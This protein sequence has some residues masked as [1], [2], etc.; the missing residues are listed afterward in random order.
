M[1]LKAVISLTLTFFFVWSQ[2]CLANPK[3]VQAGLCPKELD[4]MPILQNGRLK[5]LYVHSKETFS[6]LGIKVKGPLT[7]TQ[8]YCL[9]SLEGL[10]VPNDLNLQTP[11]QHIKLRKFLE[12][13]EDQ[14]TVSFKTLLKKAEK[15][16][17]KLMRMK[18]ETSE[19]KAF[20]KI[21]NKIHLYNSIRTSNDWTLFDKDKTGGTTWPVLG[22]YLTEK[23][24]KKTF[25]NYPSENPIVKTLLLTKKDYIQK[26]G[27]RYLVEYHFVKAN[28]P[29]W[30]LILSLVTLAS[31]TLF[32]KRLGFIL[33]C[34]GATFLLQLIMMV[35]RIYI[36]GRAPITNMYET[37][38]FSGFGCLA[39][40]LLIGH[41]KKEKVFVF[42]GVG[43]NILT[44]LMINFADGMLNEQISPLVPVLRDNFWLSTH[45]TTI[46]MSYG[47]LAMSWVLGN[48]ILVKKCF[49]GISK[50][51][52]KY[53]SEKVYTCL[54]W[55]TI[56]L[57]AGVI[58]G[59]VWADYSWGR[60]WGWDPK[61]TWSLIVL[62]IYM[63]ILHGRST[64]W[65]PTKRFIPLVSG[66]FMSVIMAWFGVNYILASGLH[67]YGFSEGGAI[68][69]GSFFA[70]QSLFL[71]FATLKTK[72][73]DYT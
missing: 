62:C 37:V 4:T 71:I 17:I 26:L 48:S 44:L 33:I 34:S 21:F 5:P 23:R 59:G 19:K 25:E 38:F 46:I 15:L 36:S 3:N 50:E 68:F 22:S 73:Y 61:E 14:K 72:T 69:I 10:K 11:I 31:M 43:Y 65:I 60:F 55:G 67:S 54:K 20:Q 49:F 58:L 66:A 64:S 2:Q 45:V 30:C 9:L 18:E 24:V 32:R 35:L 12:L 40:G 7:P 42:I 47:A 57:A 70:V 39:L 27:D 13:K 1:N 28:L 16:R 63:A 6:L 53:L 8:T 56:L 51:E 29:F 52:E 41:L